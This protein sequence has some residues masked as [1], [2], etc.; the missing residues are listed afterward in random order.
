VESPD[1]SAMQ[2]IS[3]TTVEGIGIVL[4][5]ALLAACSVNLAL[6]CAWL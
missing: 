3:K 5:M 4:A 6:L 1:V 2:V